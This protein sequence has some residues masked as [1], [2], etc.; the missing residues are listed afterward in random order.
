[1]MF[2]NC[3]VTKLEY[4]KSFRILFRFKLR[5]RMVSREQSGS[6]LMKIGVRRIGPLGNLYNDKYNDSYFDLLW[7]NH[8]LDK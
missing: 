8:L 3:S 7:K 2:F 1:M 5:Q 4:G 6:N